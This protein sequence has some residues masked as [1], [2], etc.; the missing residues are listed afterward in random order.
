MVSLTNVNSAKISTRKQATVD[1]AF[2]AL[3]TL[4]VNTVKTVSM[5]FFVKIW[6]QSIETN[7]STANAT[8]KAQSRYSAHQMASALANRA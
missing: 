7:V 1:T 4:R 3:E 2:N 8:W 5:A 6:K